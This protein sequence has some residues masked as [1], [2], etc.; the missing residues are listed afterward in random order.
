MALLT[1]KGRE[2]T[3]DVKS[4]FCSHQMTSKVLK[5]KEKF[6]AERVRYL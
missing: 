5:L 6:D 4:D 1:L 2:S 3:S